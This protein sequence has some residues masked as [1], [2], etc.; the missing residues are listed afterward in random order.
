MITLLQMNNN[1]FSG[2][3]PSEMGQL[4]LMSSFLHFNG[5]SFHGEIPSQFGQLTSL[6]SWFFAFSNHLCGDVPKEVAALAGNA[7]I[8][9]DAKLPHW[10]LYIGNRLGTDCSITETPTSA[11]NTDHGG[12][13][14]DFMSE[15]SSNAAA[16]AAIISVCFLFLI[17]VS[18]LIIR[19][20]RNKSMEPARR[21]VGDDEDDPSSKT[22]PMSHK[23]SPASL[24]EL[25]FELD[26]IKMV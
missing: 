19:Y 8:P 22:S 18:L 2:P 16:S 5:N 26:D 20:I 4:S 24:E 14:D 10:S 25:E 1:D 15:V 13:N 7:S 11:P 3:L 9:A 23:K 17:G 6:T 12:S 21:D